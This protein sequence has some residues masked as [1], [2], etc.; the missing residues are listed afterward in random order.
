MINRDFSYFYSNNSEPEKDDEVLHRKIKELEEKVQR[1][2]RE[3]YYIN[4]IALDLVGKTP[5]NQREHVSY[6]YAMWANQDELPNVRD[7]VK[8]ILLIQN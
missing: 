3:L 7:L 8:S 6:C 4:T 1:L 2:E 5:I